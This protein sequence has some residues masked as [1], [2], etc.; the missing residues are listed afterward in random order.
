MKTNEWIVWLE[1]GGVM[2]MNSEDIS[3][4]CDHTAPLKF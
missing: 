4:N 2:L 3:Y 1:N